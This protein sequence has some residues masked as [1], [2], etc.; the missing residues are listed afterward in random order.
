MKT[1]KLFRNALL[2][3]GLIAAATVHTTAVQAQETEP[4]SSSRLAGVALAAGAVRVSAQ[5]IPAEITDAFRSLMKAAGPK[6][7]QGQTELLAWTGGNY[8]KARVPNIKSKVSTNLQQAGWTYEE[9]KGDAGTGPMTLVSVLRTTPTRKALI[10]FWVPSDDALILAWTEMLPAATDDAITSNTDEP[11]D[12]SDTVASDASDDAGSDDTASDE[13]ATRIARAPVSS[14]STTSSQ[15]AAGATTF[16]ITGNKNYVNVM[17]TAMPKLPSFPALSPKGGYVRG[18]V[19][20]LKGKPLQGA[21][22]GA[23]STSA[24]GFYSGASAKTD[25]KGYYEIQVPWGAA[26]FY[27]AGYT[28]DWGEGR[29]ALGLHPADGEASS[30]ATANGLVENWVL[31]H[32]GIADRDKASEQPHYSGNYYGGTFSVSYSVADSRPIFADN[33]SLPAG[34]EIELTLTP[35]GPLLDGSKGRIFVVRQGIEEGIGRGFYVNNIPLGQYKLQARLIQGG[36]KTP[37]LIK[38]TGPYSSQPFGLEPKEAR[39][40][41]I[42]TFRPGGAQAGMALGQHGNWGSLNITLYR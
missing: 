20:D 21:V 24:G 26:H 29:A 9:T 1:I 11:D 5:H 39:G 41:T 17:K 42:M 10:G 33:Y 4:A 34:A 15:S 25:A 30:F 40:E 19:K 22:I 23:R 6:V 14:Q 31:I 16:S 2:W 12:S 36:S 35:N 7:K 32:Y 27:A 18:Y 38:E 3:A 28:V 8:K 37:L 13:P